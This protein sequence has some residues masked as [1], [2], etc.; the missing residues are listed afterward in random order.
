M[1]SPL[2]NIFGIIEKINVMLNEKGHNIK[3]FDQ[4]V[5]ESKITSSLALK[6]YNCIGSIEGLEAKQILLELLITEKKVENAL[7]DL[8]KLKTEAARIA[9]FIIA[10]NSKKRVYRPRLSKKQTM[11]KIE[12]LEKLHSSSGNIKNEKLEENEEKI[13]LNL[14]ETI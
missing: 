14:K 13:E 10:C 8:Q 6:N 3:N 4:A 5:C 7:Q 11:E 9:D 12:K 1:A 2:S